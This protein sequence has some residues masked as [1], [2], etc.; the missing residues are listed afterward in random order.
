MI[1]NEYVVCVLATRTVK[2]YFRK[3]PDMF[4]AGRA[5]LCQALV[6]QV[7]LGQA[8]FPRGWWPPEV[9]LV[10]GFQVLSSLCFREQLPTVQVL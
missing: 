4:Q 5:A 10:S 6:Y 3:H 8:Y 7:D 2:A 1:V 9:P